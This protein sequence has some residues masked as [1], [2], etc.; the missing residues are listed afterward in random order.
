MPDDR[1]ELS[2]AVVEGDDDRGP[3]P[4]DR[5]EEDAW[6]AENF[7]WIKA[8]IDEAMNDFRP[9]LTMEEVDA[10]MEQ[11]FRDLEAKSGR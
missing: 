11:T 5:A 7:D 3:A 10:R 8:R 4:E 6:M 9:A 1:P 2:E